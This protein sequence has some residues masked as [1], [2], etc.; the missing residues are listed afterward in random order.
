MT[1]AFSFE[2]EEVTD[3]AAQLPSVKLQAPDAYPRGTLLTLQVQV[4]VKSVRIDSDRQD[5]LIRNHMLA[6]EDVNVVDVLTPAQRQ[7]LLEAT[8]RAAETDAAARFGEGFTVHEEV[9]P[10]QL[11]V[12]EAIAEAVAESGV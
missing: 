8:E 6:Y 12:D 4:R 5:K 10:G 7:A 1:E 9:I 11:T 3:F 2:G